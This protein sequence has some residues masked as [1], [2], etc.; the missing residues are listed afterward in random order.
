MS[1]FLTQ[2]LDF[3]GHLSTF[4]AENTRKG[5]YFKTENNS[6]ILPKQT[7]KNFEKV[8]NTAFGTPK[9]PKHG[10]LFGKK[11]QFLIPFSINELYF[12]LVGI[13]KQI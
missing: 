2:N 10:C 13:K 9:W 6:Q 3:W 4:G 11:G 12:L 7:L 1:K 5:W 8:Q